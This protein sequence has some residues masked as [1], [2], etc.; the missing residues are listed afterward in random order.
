L[1]TLVIFDTYNA[2][3]CSEDLRILSKSLEENGIFDNVGI[4]FRLP[5]TETGIEFN[6]FIAD[7]KYNCQLDRDTKIVAVQ[8]GKIPKFFLKS[9]WKPMSVISIGSS[10]KQTKTAVYAS[11]CDLIISYTSQ[12]PII[13]TRT[14]WE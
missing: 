13:E 11:M 8:N 6:K 4:Y 14:L 9:D 10:L 5:N 12:Q 1:P 2:K 3:Q 7:K